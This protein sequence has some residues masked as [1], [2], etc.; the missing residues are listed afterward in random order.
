[1]PYRTMDKVIDGVVITCND[2]TAAKK[3]EHDLLD[4]FAKLEAQLSG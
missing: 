1:M 4:K 3:I 2:I